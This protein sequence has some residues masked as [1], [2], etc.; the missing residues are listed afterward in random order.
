MQ[1]TIQCIVTYTPVPFESV[2]IHWHKSNYYN[3]I[4]FLIITIGQHKH[5]IR[6]HI[7]DTISLCSSQKVMVSST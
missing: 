1:W 6:I 4:L 3:I 2:G 5:H 7:H